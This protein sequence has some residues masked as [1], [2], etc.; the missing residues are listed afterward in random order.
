MQLSLQTPPA[1][2]RLSLAAATLSLLGS[3]APPAAQAEGEP[4]QWIFDSGLLLYKENGGRVQVVEPVVNAAVDLGKERLLSAGFVVDSLTGATPNGAAPASTA[5]TFTAPSGR[6]NYSIAPGATPLDKSFHDT[7]IAANVGYRFAL[8]PVSHLAF[9]LHGSKEYDFTSVGGNTQYSLDLNQKN[10]TLNAGLAYEYD[11]VSPVGGAPPALSRMVL[12]QSGG[13]G[14]SEP[15][16]GKTKTVA[17]VLLGVTQVIDDKSLV[18]FDYSLSLSNG[19]QTDPYKILSVVDA[20]ATPQYYVY[21]RRPGVR[22]KHALFGEYKRQVFGRDVVDLSYRYFIDSWGVNAH[23]LT[24]SYRWNFS[25]HQ[26]LEP[27]TRWYRQSAANFFHTALFTGQDTTVDYASADPRLG[28]FDAAT[29]GLKYGYVFRNG[30]EATIR[31]EYYQQFG[32]VTE[33][34]EQAAAALS[35]FNLAP[36]LSAINLTVGYRFNW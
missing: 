26:Y 17:D 8:N 6:K 32:H 25:E 29:G 21:E 12:G 35:K 7:R 16:A 4:R 5:Q 31:I 28:A 36:G 18:Q 23:T 27:R 22:T 2:K 1:R 19:Y 30:Q 33:V 9:G 11:Q 14:G 15:G 3:A 34:P 20:S 10:T 24:T 13:G